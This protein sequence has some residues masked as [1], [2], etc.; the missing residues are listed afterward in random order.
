MDVL[1]R[2]PLVASL[3]STAIKY[4]TAA[5]MIVVQQQSMGG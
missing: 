1:L 5:N 3:Y 4:S 2:D